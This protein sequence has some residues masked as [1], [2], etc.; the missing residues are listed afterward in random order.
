M[1]TVDFKLFPVRSGERVLDIGCGAGRHSWYVCKQNHCLLYAMDLDLESLQKN[2]Y[3]LTRIAQENGSEGKWTVLQGDVQTLPFEDGT[4]DKIICSEVLEHVID[5]ERGVKE[6]VRVL[7]DGGELAVSVPARMMETIYWKLSEAYHTNP[8]GHIR[9]YRKD[10]LINLLCRNDLTVY[11]V[12][13]KHAL[14]SIYWLLRCLFGVRRENAIIPSLYHKFLTWEIDNKS[15]FFYRVEKLLDHL[16]PKS[17][18]IY[19]K[20]ED[21][22]EVA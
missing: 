5:D 6:L 12:R 4:F 22:Q 16:F 13:Y 2:I 21:G 20:K 14:H 7:K 11:A 3:M 15:K 9:I 8:G 18:V 17:I 10:Q 1:L 19:L